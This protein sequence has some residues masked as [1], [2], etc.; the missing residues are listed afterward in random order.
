MWKK[1][2]SIMMNTGAVWH[3]VY[4]RHGFKDALCAYIQGV[5]DNDLRYVICVEVT[6]EQYDSGA[7]CK[8]LIDVL[9]RCY[10]K[11]VAGMTVVEDG[12]DLPL[13]SAAGE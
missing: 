5:A 3:P 12:G 10:S 11:G 9:Q 8:R 2:P 4:G 7:G 6:G 1:Q 13:D